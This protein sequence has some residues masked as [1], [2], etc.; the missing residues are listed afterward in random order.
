MEKLTQYKSKKYFHNMNDGNAFVNKKW[1]EK[2]QFK[3][4]MEFAL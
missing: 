4:W 1:N 3:D 2:F